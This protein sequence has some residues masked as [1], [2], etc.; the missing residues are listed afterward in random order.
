MA[1]ATFSQ[2]LDRLKESFLWAAAQGG[3]TQDCESL[4][5]IGADVNWRNH[6]GDTPLLAAC[7]RGH[8]ETANVLIVHGADVNAIGDDSYTP[9]H[10]ACRRGNYELLSILL[11]SN[12]D[13]FLQTL[14]GETAMD[15][16][17]LK[18]YEDIYNRLIQYLSSHSSSSGT[19][20]TAQNNTLSLQNSLLDRLE[21]SAA[22]VQGGGGGGGGS[23]TVS[24]SQ[25]AS[26]RGSRHPLLPALQ[27]PSR[28]QTQSQSQSQSSPSLPLSHSGTGPVPIGTVVQ[29]TT[30]LREVLRQSRSESL[31]VENKTDN[32]TSSSYT[33]IGQGGER[34]REKERERGGSEDQQNSLSLRKM[35][36]IEHRERKAAEAKLDLMRQQMNRLISELAEFKTHVEIMETEKESLGEQVRFLR[37]IG[38]EKLDLQKCEELERDLRS[39]LSAVE[40]R[41]TAL[42]HEEISN[43]N[44]MRVCVI[45]K[46]REKSVLLLPCRH[47][48][49]CSSCADHEKLDMCPLCRRAIVHKISVYS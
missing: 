4:I 27:P 47:L 18:G 37:G 24:G 13:I 15:I 42:I 8:I 32:T 14:D 29:K 40:M 3:N 7:R 49:L 46:E 28:S 45:C 43:K 33:L 38:L 39:A 2:S 34:E 5:D 35:F 6:E 19:N 22:Q 20:Q 25:D 1:D 16:A 36:D 30:P 10:I 23:P 31:K 17:Q 48:C 26:R 41:K 21:A 44:E 9:L 12:A 11:E